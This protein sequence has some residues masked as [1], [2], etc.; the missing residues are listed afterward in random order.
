MIEKSRNYLGPEYEMRFHP[1]RPLR[2]AVSLDETRSPKLDAAGCFREVQQPASRFRRPKSLGPERPET[3][4][5][6]RHLKMQERARE[7]HAW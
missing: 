2:A 6:F 5:S 4:E 3:P 7:G 1:A